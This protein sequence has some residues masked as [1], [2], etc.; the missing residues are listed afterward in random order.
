MR[1]L[2][3]LLLGIVLVDGLEVYLCWHQ[4]SAQSR[5]DAAQVKEN[6]YKEKVRQDIIHGGWQH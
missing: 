1:T 2:Y 6:L 5:R 3:A 4:A